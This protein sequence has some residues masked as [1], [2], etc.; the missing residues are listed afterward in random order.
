MY[1]CSPLAG[2]A[3]LSQD[4]PSS[5]K[6]TFQIELNGSYLSTLAAAPPLRPQGGRGWQRDCFLYYFSVFLCNPFKELSRLAFSSAA[7]A[8][9]RLIHI[10]TKFFGENFMRKMI[11]FTF[12]DINQ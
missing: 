2:I 8:K 4:A 10:P 7:N 1:L 9:V 3:L 6:C 12:L 11:F 5:S